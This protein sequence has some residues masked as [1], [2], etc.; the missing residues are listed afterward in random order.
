ME[1]VRG[2]LRKTTLQVVIL[3]N[4]LF[5][6]ALRAKAASEMTPSIVAAER[7][8]WTA[9]GLAPPDTDPAKML[10][11]VLDEQVAGFYDPSTKA[12][13]VR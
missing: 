13:T 12:L 1:D 4:E 8:R 2:L 7:A 6:K 11:T 5:S 3:D 9:F 10:L